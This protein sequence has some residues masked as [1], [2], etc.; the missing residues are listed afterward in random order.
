MLKADVGRFPSRVAG[1]FRKP[2]PDTVSNVRFLVRRTGAVD[3]KR[4]IDHSPALLQSGRRKK[5]AI[6]QNRVAPTPLPLVRSTLDVV[7][8]LSTAVREAR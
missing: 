3:L 1:P 2:T 4:P 7:L 6:R 5:G 8:R